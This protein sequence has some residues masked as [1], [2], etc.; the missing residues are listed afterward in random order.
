MIFPLFCLF[1]ATVLSRTIKDFFAHKKTTA[2]FYSSVVSYIQTI[3]FLQ[4][5][6]FH[7]NGVIEL[8][9]SLSEPVIIRFQC[10]FLYQN[11]CNNEY[12][13]DQQCIN[14]IPAFLNNQY[15]HLY[16]YGLGC[17]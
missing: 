3:L 6:T 4:H 10:V 12:F 8:A 13:I 11:I 7:L 17:N 5:Q 1:I 9:A 15:I 14:Q 2:E 16:K